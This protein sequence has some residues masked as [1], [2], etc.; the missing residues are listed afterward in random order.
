MIG[1][2]PPSEADNSISDSSIANMNQ[3]FLK[4]FCEVVQDSSELGMTFV[5]S[6]DQLSELTNPPSWLSPS[7]LCLMINGSWGFQPIKTP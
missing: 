4:C 1:L 5:E 7:V 2:E 6:E 3:I